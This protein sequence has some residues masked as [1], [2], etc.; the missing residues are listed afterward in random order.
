VD[1]LCP[2]A[3]ERRTVKFRA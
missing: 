2:V 1:Q 3:V